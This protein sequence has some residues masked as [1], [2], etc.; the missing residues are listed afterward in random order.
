MLTEENNRSLTRVGPGT[1]M[2]NLMRQYWQPVLLSRELPERDGPPLRVRHLCEDLLAYRDSD[3]RVGLVAENCP[4]RGASLFFGRNEEAGLRCVYH[5][6][7]FD[8]TGACIDMPNEPAESNFKHKIRVTSYPCSERN[9]VIWTY[10]GP[11]AEPPGLP[12]LEWNL[13]PEDQVYFSKR[14]AQNNWVQALEGDIDSS[15]SAFLHGRSTSPEK[16]AEVAAGIG[17]GAYYRTRGKSAFFEQVSTAFGIATAS[18][19]PAEE[20]SYYWRLNQF[21]MPFFTLIP[22][23]GA[24]PSFLGHV[25]LPMDDHHVVALGIQY[26]PSAPLPEAQLQSLRYGQDGLQTSHPTVDVYLP[27]TSRPAG[28]W[29]PK[30]NINNDFGLDYEAQRTQRFSGLPGTWPQDSGMQETM[31]PIYNRTREHLGSTDSGIIAMRRR[32]LNAARALQAE[33]MTPPGVDDPHAYFIRSVSAILPRTESWVEGTRELMTART[34][35]SYD[36]P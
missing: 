21:L 23:Y 14:V 2:G 1:L 18:R 10:M 5:G 6:W 4:H 11:R 3:G 9:G 12:D 31:G 8:V 33:Q 16:S 24:S 28:A 25:W 36:A 7:K 27:A 15:H 29:W 32:L 17:K 13:V 19:R 20:D 35:V 30:L 34:G 22:P 26:H